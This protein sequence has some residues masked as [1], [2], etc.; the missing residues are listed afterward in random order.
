MLRSVVSYNKKDGF[1]YD[2][3]YEI[4]IFNESVQ[5]FFDAN[6]TA[7]RTTDLIDTM[8]IKLGT[9][10]KLAYQGLDSDDLPYAWKTTI[11]MMTNV[12]RTEL[13][14]N[15]LRVITEA[16]RI[17]CK[18]RLSN[19]NQ[20]TAVTEVTNLIANIRREETIRAKKEAKA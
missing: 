10:V 16:E 2:K 13:D 20:K 11:D 12:V 18:V 19:G 3:G 8:F 14:N 9:M 17:V 1:K 6:T 7:E 4:D 5:S 15:Y